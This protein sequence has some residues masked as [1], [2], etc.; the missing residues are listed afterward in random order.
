MPDYKQMYS[1]LF[2]AVSEAVELLQNAQ[3]ETEEL[4]IKTASDDTPL[5]L[6]PL[7]DLQQ[8]IDAQNKFTSSD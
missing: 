3:A 8:G 5:M 6:L 7:E 2:N 1:K 4:F